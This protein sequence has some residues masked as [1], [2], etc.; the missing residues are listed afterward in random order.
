[1][2]PF[3]AV[4]L[5][6]GSLTGATFVGPTPYLSAVDSPFS[7]TSF[8]Y[9]YLEDFQDGV[10]NTPGVNANSGTAVFGVPG[11]SV[12]SVEGP[13]LVSWYVSTNTVRFTFSS[14]VLGS[15][16][17]HAGIVWTDVGFVS[18]GVA[19]LSSVVFEAF[20]ALGVS[21]GV[22]GPFTLG[23][24]G[25]NGGQSEDRFFGATNAGGISAIELRMPDSTDWELDHLQ[26]GAESSAVPEPG[27]GLLA[28]AAVAG[29]MLMR[30]VRRA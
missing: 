2:R 7:G 6:C 9:S 3:L 18:S 22:A 1:M 29:A 19:G 11:G 17:T 15:L 30:R 12:D 24:G 21:L 10:L 16:P 8:S 14:A 4:V 5:F 25:V 13:T 26:Y 23:D 27:T 20:D 28:T